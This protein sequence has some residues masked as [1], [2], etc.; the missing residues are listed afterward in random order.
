MNG[1]WRNIWPDIVTNFHGSNPEE[2]IGSSRHSIV[3]MAMS[4]GFED[5]DEAIVEELF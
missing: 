4:V 3:D 5:L 2:E 1:V